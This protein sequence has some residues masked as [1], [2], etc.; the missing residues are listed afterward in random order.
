MSGVILPP[1]KP[2]TIF[3]VKPFAMPICGLVE[4]PSMCLSRMALAWSLA[5]RSP[6]FDSMLNAM[7][8]VLARVMLAIFVNDRFFVNDHF[9]RMRAV[10][11]RTELRHC[12][13]GPRREA[14]ELLFSLAAGAAVVSSWLL[15]VSKDLVVSSPNY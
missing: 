6:T 5:S 15:V 3:R 7:S 4:K 13:T 1:E 10:R 8:L 2:A 12:R 11:C 14:S 9:G